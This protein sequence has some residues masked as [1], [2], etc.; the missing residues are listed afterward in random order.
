MP[1]QS[2]QTDPLQGKIALITGAS[3]GIG[4]ATALALGRRGCSIAVHYNAA[5][6]KADALV[7]ELSQIG[8]KAIAF[9]AEMGNF[10][11]VRKLHAD[12]VEQLGH[13]DILFNNAGRTNTVVGM[14]GDMGSISIDEF[15]HTWRVNTAS[16]Y[17]LTQLC[18]PNMVQNKFGRI[19]FCSSVAAGVG[20]VIGPHYASSKSALHGLLHWIAIR[21]A[22]DGV[23]CNAVAPALI[24]ETSMFENPSEQLKDKIPVGRFGLPHEIASVVEMLVSNAYMT[25]KIIVSDGG[26]TPSA[27]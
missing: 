27:F 15:E 5:K 26:M 2:S 20:G 25:N 10:D 13:P 17:L 9:Q 8:V 1:D 19:V 6:A 12:V 14:W 16:S 21:H 3:G 18:L 23:T 4:Y 24:I 11:Q 22:K 7:A